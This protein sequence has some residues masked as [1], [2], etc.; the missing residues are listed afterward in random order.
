MIA[1][2]TPNAG[3]RA[4]ARLQAAGLVDG[5]ITQNVDGLHTAAGSAEVVELHG[6]L[7]EVVCLGC[8]NHTSR[9]EVQRRLGQANPGFDA[10][11]R[12]GPPGR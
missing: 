12:R 6:R 1:G 9:A 5:V 3:H 8:G 7:D 4:V 11:V 10:A 2:A